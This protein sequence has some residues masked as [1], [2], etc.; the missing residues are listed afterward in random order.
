MSEKIEVHDVLVELGESTEEGELLGS[1]LEV[2]DIVEQNEVLA[3]VD[4]GKVTVELVAPVSGRVLEITP[5]GPATRGMVAVRIEEIA[6]PHKRA[7]LREGLK[8]RRDLL[9]KAAAQ[10]A[11]AKDRAKSRAHVPAHQTTDAKA[12]TLR[13]GE[14]ARD[15]HLAPIDARIAA[16]TLVAGAEAATHA[17][18]VVR[19]LAVA[20]ELS[21]GQRPYG[22]AYLSVRAG[23]E[24]RTILSV[25][26][27]DDEGDV[28]D[29]TELEGAIVDA[30]VVR[31]HDTVQHVGL[32]MVS[33]SVDTIVIS[34]P[35]V[36]PC[37]GPDGAVTHASRAEVSLKLGRDPS[38]CQRVL[39]ALAEQLEQP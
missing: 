38:L 21:P 29:I 37:L 31:F 10:R 23:V 12:L 30:V 35:R 39:A 36:V 32:V 34:A 6:D 18:R 11:A 14:V 3:E 5:P 22:I 1:R 8:V 2:G 25:A 20:P 9:A 33:S 15:V 19:A 13:I 7:T 16:L 4:L 24:T 26:I 17:L 27:H 28:K